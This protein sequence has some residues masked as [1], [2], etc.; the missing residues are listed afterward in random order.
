MLNMSCGSV[1]AKAVNLKS[2][3]RTDV[4]AVRA[5]LQSLVAWLTIRVSQATLNQMHRP[6]STHGNGLRI[7]SRDATYRTPGGI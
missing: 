7:E 5:V 3:R 2:T 1:G 4:D 6:S